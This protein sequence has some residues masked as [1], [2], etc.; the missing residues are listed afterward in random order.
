MKRI[1]FISGLLA[2]MSI[3]P[4]CAQE[5]TPTKGQGI[6]AEGKVQPATAPQRGDVLA[7]SNLARVLNLTDEQRAR[8]EGLWKQYNDRN[9]ALRRDTAITP[10]QRMHRMGQNRQEYVRLVRTVL[11]EDQ[12]KRFEQLL[13]E[14]SPANASLAGMRF[15]PQQMEKIKEISQRYAKLRQEISQDQSLDP[16]VKARRL[17]ELSQQMLKEIRDKVLTEQQREQWD[18]A[19]K[20]D[21][22][23]N[24]QDKQ[25]E[26]D[27]QK[28]KPSGGQ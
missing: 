25:N 20:K 21:Q 19:M 10:E 5:E 7:P 23:T 11:K 15:T 18:K 26:K 13:E 12:L 16:S 24:A 3:A 6:P 17:Q 27:K 9:E 1:W 28:N 8:I 4:I 22:K 2:L 14:Q